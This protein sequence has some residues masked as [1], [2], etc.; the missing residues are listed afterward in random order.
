MSSEDGQWIN[1]H[2]EGLVPE[3]I[4]KLVTTVETI[5]DAVTLAL[6]TE[7]AIMEVIATL[8]MDVLNA[9]AL[10]IKG[11]IAAIQSAL[12]PL[13]GDARLHVLAVPF[14]KRPNYK[15]L[16]STWPVQF[17]DSDDGPPEDPEE[18]KKEQLLND[19]L[20]QAAFYDGGVQGYLRTVTEALHDEDD[21][22]RPLYGNGSAILAHVW[23]AGASDI[24]GVLDA[25][26]SLEAIFGESLQGGEFV[27]KNIVR[28]PQELQL[29][30]IV[31]GPK[32][33]ALLKWENPATVQIFAQFGGL[34]VTLREIAVIR[35]TN[36]EVMKAKN[37]AD[38]FGDQQPGIITKEDQGIEI[39]D[40]LT[41]NDGQ[42]TV[43][44]QMYYDGTRSTYLDDSE[45]KKDVEYLYTLAYRYHI[46]PQDGDEEVQDYKLISNVQSLRVADTSGQHSVGI[47]P[48]WTDTPNVLALIP[49]LQF[50][51]KYIQAYLDTLKGKIVG[52]STA[53]LEYIAF[54]KSELNRYEKLINDIR[55][56]IHKLLS[57]LKTPEAGIY[58][59][60]IMLP[61][62]G[63]QEFERELARRLLDDEDSTAPPFRTGTE[64]VAGLVM[65]AG[66]PDTSGLT[67]AASFFEMFFGASSP[68]T[69]PFQNAVASIEKVVDEAAQKAV[70]LGDDL[71]P[72]N[73]VETQS[74][75]TF[76]ESMNP[77]PASSSKAKL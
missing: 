46:K 40:A 56:K 35:S 52:P 6:D 17:T 2:L 47:K 37:W 34:R 11:A 9:E 42:S 64:F 31:S 45:L 13:L 57:L 62:G 43:I 29:Q 33:G 49:D 63:V 4:K 7:I 32:V 16:R 30:Q 70:T 53:L 3:A 67:Q 21:E 76:D 41:S 39:P 74:Y 55:N 59:T 72:G 58:A 25:L 15:L 12:D 66:T 20:R 77:V 5:V 28:T 48:N 1:V 61:Q 24:L 44:M 27:P 73:T 18:A 71:K 69:T 14:R 54:L 26:L 68:V 75:S 65:L 51:V 19:K 23:V 10:I 8:V 38:I 36:P 60:T 22:G 50:Y